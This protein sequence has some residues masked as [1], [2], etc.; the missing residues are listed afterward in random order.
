MM[1]PKVKAVPTDMK[2]F[3]KHWKNIAWKHFFSISNGGFLKYF[4]NVMYMQDVKE[5]SFA[6]LL[7]FFHNIKEISFA[8]L[9]HFFHITL[10]K[11]FKK[12]PFEMQKHCVSKQ[13]FLNILNTLLAHRDRIADNF[14][15]IN[16]FSL[17]KSNILTFKI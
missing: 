1:I 11:Y 17:L 13:C 6:Y 7:H 5:I 3:Q 4:W 9:S 2:S 14:F 8:Y 12:S 16:M 15:R 10:Q